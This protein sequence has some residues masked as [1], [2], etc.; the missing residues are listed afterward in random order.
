MAT[1]KKFSMTGNKT[2]VEAFKDAQKKK[3][4]GK[5]PETTKKAA[6][7][8]PTAKTPKTQ[9]D[10]KKKLPAAE[11]KRMQTDFDPPI[12]PGQTELFAETD[13]K[14]P[15]GQPRKYHEPIKRISFAL[16]ASAVEKLDALAAINHINKTQ[17]LLGVIET[18]A[19]A[20]AER[21]EKYKKL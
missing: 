1:K 9:K 17:F 16:P 5:N 15:M 6:A 13:G 19:S 12:D 3:E 20:S 18:A 2:A 7:K 14:R 8:K 11:L 10:E 21:I 4:E